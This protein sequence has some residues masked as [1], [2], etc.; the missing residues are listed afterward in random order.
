MSPT[1]APSGSPTSPPTLAPTPVCPNL[2]VIVSDQ[3]TLPFDKDNFE[4]LYVYGHGRH[5]NGRP[6]FEVPQIK[7]DKNIQYHGAHP[8][9]SWII[10]G[11]GAEE[12]IFGPTDLYYP[13]NGAQLYN[14]THSTTSRVFGV[15]ILCVQTFA[16]VA[17]PTHSPTVPPTTAPTFAPTFAP[18]HS[19]SVTPSNAPS[20]SPTNTPSAPPTNVPSDVPSDSPSAAPTVSPTSMCPTLTVRVLELNGVTLST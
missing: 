12:L 8:T 14:W 18:T 7:Y 11:E 3:G 17:A 5:V 13:P 1:I 16:P 20:T 15:V 2:N 10:E 6:I 4:G 19:P 9:G